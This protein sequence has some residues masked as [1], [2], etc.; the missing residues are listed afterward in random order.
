ME[1]DPNFKLIS[2]GRLE[3]SKRNLKFLN[4]MWPQALSQY[5]CIYLLLSSFHSP[6]II[7]IVINYIDN[8]RNSKLSNF[9]CCH[10]YNR[11]WGW[12]HF[13]L[14]PINTIGGGIYLCFLLQ[15]SDEEEQQ[16]FYKGWDFNVLLFA[17]LFT[18]CT[19]SMSKGLQKDY[20]KFEQL[21]LCSLDRRQKLSEI[22]IRLK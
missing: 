17:Y 10:K 9:W 12:V 19:S 1:L 3:A 16:F 2:G 18:C 22:K 21:L 6:W 14:A 11:W 20:N 15:C 7:V 13:F 4:A 8:K 5:I